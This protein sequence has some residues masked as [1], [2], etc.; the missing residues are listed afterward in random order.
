MISHR[1]FILSGISVAALGSLGYG[2][3]LGMPEKRA[4]FNIRFGRAPAMPMSLRRPV[5]EVII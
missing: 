4:D 1:I 5:F 2:L 3:W